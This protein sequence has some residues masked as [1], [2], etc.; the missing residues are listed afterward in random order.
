MEL[1]ASYDSVGKHPQEIRND[2]IELSDYRSPEALLKAIA[3]QFNTDLLAEFI[4]DFSMG[5][6]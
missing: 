3:S 5:R 2:F 1:N 4:D 6:I